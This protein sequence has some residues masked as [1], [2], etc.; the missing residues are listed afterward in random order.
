MTKQSKNVA[1]QHIG[2]NPDTKRDQLSYISHEQPKQTE[3][4]I[5]S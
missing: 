4:E 5:I 3:K 2:T 1:N